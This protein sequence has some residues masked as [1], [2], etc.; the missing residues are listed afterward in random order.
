MAYD[1]RKRMVAI[2]A[3]ATYNTDPIGSGPPSGTDWIKVSDP[4][5]NIETATVE[6]DGASAWP[7]GF[8]NIP[9][10]NTWRHAGFIELAPL[11]VASN[12]SRPRGWAVMQALGFTG[13]YS[14]PSTPK[15]YTAKMSPDNADSVTVWDYQFHQPSRGD[16]ASHW[17]DKISGARG[18]GVLQ[19]RN[20]AVW[21]VAYE[22]MGA[23][24]SRNNGATRP[25]DAPFVDSVGDY[26]SPATFPRTTFT[27]QDQAS[28]N[29]A[30]GLIKDLSIDLGQ[31]PSEEYTSSASRDPA[32]VDRLHGVKT[33]TMR[34]YAVSRA[35]SDPL[36][37]LQAGGFYVLTTSTPDLQD[38]DLTVGIT[39]ALTVTSV[40]KAVDGD[41]LYWDVAFKTAFPTD[42]TAYGR[43]PAADLAVIW[44]NA[45]P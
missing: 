2:V 9:T 7:S 5:T 8:R 34:L 23:S 12:T 13:V 11:A 15:I 6:D 45:T 37:V 31:A 22:L 35:I 21:G 24:G 38:A 25:T 33:G 32:F 36:A 29:V 19:L 20:G 14:N 44:T 28:G 10:Q 3:E 1:V 43:T 17:L 30:S 39:A 41:R 18:R 16:A 27:L 26:R 4:V 40:T 42:G